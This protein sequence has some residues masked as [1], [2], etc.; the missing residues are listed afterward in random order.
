MAEAHNGQILL[1]ISIVL[2]SL[3]IA[4]SSNAVVK[5]I[6]L[7]RF[8]FTP[9]S[10]TVA[11]TT[12]SSISVLG[13]RV[14]Y[15]ISKL[16]VP[17]RNTYMTP[18]VQILS[19]AFAAIGFFLLYISKPSRRPSVFLTSIVCCLVASMVSLMASLYQI[20]N[21]KTA[22]YYI[23][24]LMVSNMY[25][26]VEMRRSIPTYAMAWVSSTFLLAATLTMAHLVVKKSGLGRKAILASDTDDEHN[27]ELMA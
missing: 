13:V 21:L 22:E 17:L 27:E 11:D 25:Y 26:N 20:T 23:N 15:F 1:I 6:F 16:V 14:D 18:V 24:L 2:D 4:T 12:F 5:Q 7:A 10:T 3:L 19:V 8:R 9:I